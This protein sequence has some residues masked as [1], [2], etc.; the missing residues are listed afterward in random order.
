[1]QSRSVPYMGILGSLFII[2]NV[3]D[4]KRLSMLLFQLDPYSSYLPP[5]ILALENFKCLLALLGAVLNCKAN[6]RDLQALGRWTY[7]DF[8]MSYLTS[9]FQMLFRIAGQTPTTSEPLASGLTPISTCP[10]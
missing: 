3:N 5:N 9:F 2:S 7:A 6:P 10:S 8:D 1:M 4:S